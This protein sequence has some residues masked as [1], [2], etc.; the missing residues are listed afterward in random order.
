[1]NLK[2][3][4]RL[5]GF[6]ISLYIL[7]FIANIFLGN[8]ILLKFNII[9]VAM[10]FMIFL[11]KS[12]KVLLITTVIL[13]IFNGF[14]I[15]EL[16]F[17]SSIQY[18]VDILTVFI[19]IKIIYSIFQ[20]KRKIN[21]SMLKYIV[22]IFVLQL[23]ALLINNYSTLP[24]IWGIR[25]LYRFFIIFVG[26]QYLDIELD[27]RNVITFFKYFIMMQLGVIIFQHFKEV[28]FD[29]ISG[30]FGIK[31]TGITLIFLMFI[32]SFWISNYVHKKIKISG[33][34]IFLVIIFAQFI[35]GSVKASFFYIP[36]LLYIMII[37]S[38]IT[39]GNYKVLLKKVILFSIIIVGL[40]M[41]S[42]TL[43]LKV[44]SDFS[45]AE[46][47]YSKDYLKSILVSGSYNSDGNTINRLSGIGT[48]NDLVL[49]D[50][51][52]KII[53]VGLGNAS[54]NKY[55]S[56]QGDYFKKYSQ[57]N[58]NWFFIPYYVLENGF[59]GLGIF[60]LI[61]II[62]LFKSFKIYNQV[63]KEEEKLLVFAYI[64]CVITVLLTLIYNSALYT[65]QI[66]YF[67]WAISGLLIKFENKYKYVK[68]V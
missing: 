35:L 3:E 55:E 13:A 14:L 46:N 15:Q 47:L 17:P 5:Q 32:C 4:K 1:M 39:N 65:V 28:D 42:T 6:I 11:M 10:F 21:N 43:Y 31:G 50:Y 58:Y 26:F 34:L 18:S 7:I 12:N 57:L 40:V 37:L 8:D 19:F 53:G 61:F 25:N 41:V 27:Y 54:P 66:G 48:I 59:L 63:K 36:I 52:K 29:N 22:L 16:H 20:H 38:V 30:F 64:G 49:K 60:L 33:I 2:V 44:F 51:A 23:I 45:S 68:S 62:M 24:F 9:V 67:F 56:L